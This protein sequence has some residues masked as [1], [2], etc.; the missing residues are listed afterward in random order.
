MAKGRILA[1]DDEEFFRRMYLD[2]L[3]TE[4]YYVRAANSGAEGL[5]CLAE[6]AFDLVI[7]DME[8]P[9]MNGVETTE[10]IKRLHPDQEVMVVTGKRDV[11]FAVEAMKRGVSEYLLKPIIPE[12]FLHLIG[13]ILFRQGLRIEHQKLIDENIEYHAILASLRKCLAF[14]KVY[15]LDRLGDLI[16]D[17]LMELLR[18]EGALL[19]LTR[20][21]SPR[22]RLRSRRGL[23]KV[24]PEKESFEANPEEQR[25]LLTGKPTLLFLPGA[26][27]SA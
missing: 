8:M 6:E 24:T 11:T 10:A 23:S 7:T 18:A 15:D 2:L 21:G 27:L 5:T 26:M 12:E 13:Q 19:W 22:Y 25:R 9:G 16:L 1:I 14:L 4:G 17:T 20:Y 3:G